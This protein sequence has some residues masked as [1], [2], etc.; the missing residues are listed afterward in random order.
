MEENRVKGI[1]Y[2]QVYI[3]VSQLRRSPLLNVAGVIFG[4]MDRKQNCTLM[5]QQLFSCFCAANSALFL[6]FLL[7]HLQ[8][9]MT[10]QKFFFR[11]P[12]IYLVG[13][14]NIFENLFIF[15]KLFDRAQRSGGVL[16][17]TFRF[18]SKCGQRFFGR[19]WLIYIFFLLTFICNL[20]L[21]KI[22]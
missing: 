9:E 12:S 20:F 8:L 21:L 22:C 3:R 6:G 7:D 17:L 14:Q 15:I 11:S 19:F 1:E 18:L 5:R 13:S 10:F 2:I 4:M 16:G